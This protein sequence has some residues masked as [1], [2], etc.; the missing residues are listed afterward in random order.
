MSGERL[1]SSEDSLLGG[2][3][4]FH[5]P[6]DG[7]RAAIDPV[8][9]AAAVPARSGDRVLDLGTGAGA[10]FLCLLARCPDIQ[11]MGI[12]QD[13]AAAALARENAALNGWGA[14]VEIVAGG[15][16]RAA[17]GAFDQ[18]LFNPR[19]PRPRQYRGRGRA[20]RLD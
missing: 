15:L 16:D 19:W 8:L 12:E 4:I 10:A 1:D 2:R 7:Y 11:I 18:A 6:V 9:L 3:V 17:E 14:R 5:Q 20:H 13:P